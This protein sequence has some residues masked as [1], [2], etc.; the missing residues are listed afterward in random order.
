MIWLH[1]NFNKFDPSLEVKKTEKNYPH[2]NYP[3]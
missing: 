2:I 3:D 1:S